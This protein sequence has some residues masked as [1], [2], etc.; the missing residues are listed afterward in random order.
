MSTD[1]VD[2]GAGTP[3]AP[4]PGMDRDTLRGMVSELLGIELT[5]RTTT[6]ASSNSACS[7]WR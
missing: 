1:S 5:P 7:R 4:A 2:L 6:A 3:V